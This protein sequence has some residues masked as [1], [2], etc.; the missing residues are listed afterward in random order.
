MKRIAAL[1]VVFLA[2]GC[3][4]ASRDAA[5]DTSDLKFSAPTLAG[6]IFDTAAVVGV[7]PVVFWV[8]APWCPTC[9]KEAP[10]VKAAFDQYGDRVQ[11]I[12]IAGR[13][14]IDAMNEFANRHELTQMTNL[15]SEDGSLWTKVG[16]PGQPSWVFVDK[17]SNVTRHIGPHEKDKLFAQLNAL[18]S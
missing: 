16:V 1:A 3:S 12:G 6:Q 18:S 4:A 10:T 8:W 17:E 2:A 13:D 5:S 9:N 14:N 11:F 7:K 15:V